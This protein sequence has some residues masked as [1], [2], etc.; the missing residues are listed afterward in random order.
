MKAE[1]ISIGTELLTGQTINTNTAFLGEEL[2]ELGI[3][4]R[5]QS[6]VQ[7]SIKDIQ[8]VLSIALN[9]AEL[10]ITTGGLG[11]TSDDLTHKAIFSFFNL[12]PILDKT[13]LKDIQTKFKLKG[14]RKMPK[15]NL[16]QA[17][18]PKN[19]KWI[20]N[21]LGTANGIIWKINKEQSKLILT[22]PGVPREMQQMWSDSIKPYLNNLSKNSFYSR[23][24]KYTGIGESAL[25]EK[26]NQ[27]FYLKNPIV[28][29][30]ASIGE[31]KI[32][33]TGSAKTKDQAKR[34]AMKT[35]DKILRKTKEYFFGFNNETLE[36][37]TA[38]KLVKF[39]KTIAI[40]ESCTGGLLSKRLTDIP[41]SSNYI[42]LNVITYSNE[43]K[44]KL[45]KIP[46]E[47]LK[48]YGAVSPQVAAL[49]AKNIKQLADTDF[50]ISIT[51]IAGPGGGSKAKSVG[52][53]YFGF[54]KGNNIKIKKMQFG[55]NSTRDEI[56][57][58][59]TQFALNWLRKE[60]YK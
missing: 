30:Y 22:F 57:F 20:R 49:M 44:N 45:L 60:L 6:C 46:N 52:L 43:A 47:I 14:Y 42:K 15:I 17:Y 29:P 38:D 54:A 28:A 58:L 56:R 9:R 59:A 24:L 27:Y 41:G 39:K 13:V 40:A 34:I 36:G 35:T 25:A 23:T 53:V 7:D 50:G 31:V 37:L 11:P 51:G 26:I 5:Y 32:K 16:K 10:I 55:Q 8:E 3:D 2:Q 21:K 1:I 4:L 48:K 19:A 18:K 33:V 12:N